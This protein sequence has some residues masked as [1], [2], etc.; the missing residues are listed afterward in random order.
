VTTFLLGLL[1]GFATGYPFGLFIDRL[2]KRVR[3]KR[4]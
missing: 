2:D 4:T 1:I 3:Q